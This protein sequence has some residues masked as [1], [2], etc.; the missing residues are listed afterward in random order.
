MFVAVHIYGSRSNTSVI[1][2]IIFFIDYYIEYLFGL[3]SSSMVQMP[4]LNDKIDDIFTNAISIESEI[5]RRQV[6]IFIGTHD[7]YMNI[8][9]PCRFYVVE[10]NCLLNFATVSW[11]SYHDCSRAIHKW[12]KLLLL[13]QYKSSRR[14]HFV[15]WSYF[16]QLNLHWSLIVPHTMFTRFFFQMHKSALLCSCS[17][18]VCFISNLVFERMHTHEYSIFEAITQSQEVFATKM[19]TDAGKSAQEATR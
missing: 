2:C 8:R 10:I 19:H 3:F 9:F 4:K 1:C 7:C 16:W 13:L 6:Y 17:V 5:E 18:L 11:N 12:N 15:R 14:N